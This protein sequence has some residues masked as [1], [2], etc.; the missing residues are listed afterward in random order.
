MTTYIW[1]QMLAGWRTPEGD[2]L[3]PPFEG[4]R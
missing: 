3:P 4:Q 1:S 2:L